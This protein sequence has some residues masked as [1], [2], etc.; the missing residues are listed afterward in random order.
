MT[1]YLQLTEANSNELK[2][3]LPPA[4][5]RFHFDP[6][7]PDDPELMGHVIVHLAQS[8]RPDIIM[9][10]LISDEGV[11]LCSTMGATHDFQFVSTGTAKLMD[12][13]GSISKALAIGSIEETI[14]RADCGYLIVVPV[15]RHILLVASIM[16]QANLGIVMLDIRE[17]VRALAA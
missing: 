11:L 1:R 12:M 9:V 2:E 3:L 13:I 17:A 8:T 7:A 6:S 15:T 4:T 16:P 5:R 14:V 10:E